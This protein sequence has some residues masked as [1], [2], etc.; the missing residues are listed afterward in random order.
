MSQENVEIVRTALEAST[1]RDHEATFA[2]YGPEVE[3]L[4]LVDGGV[5]RG[6]TGV[7]A[8]FRDWFAAWSELSYDAEEWIDAD[9]DVIAALHVRARGRQSGVPVERREWRLRGLR[10]LFPRAGPGERGHSHGQVL[11][12]VRG[13]HRVAAAGNP[14]CVLRVP[15]TRYRVHESRN[16][17]IAAHVGAG[18]LMNSGVARKPRRV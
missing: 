13:L 18:L 16:R 1:R 12:A 11:H 10:G 14:R 15:P 8:F 2:L 6:L 17:R 3:I 9:K 4:G 7:R 5:Y